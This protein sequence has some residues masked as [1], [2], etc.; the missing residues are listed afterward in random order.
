VLLSLSDAAAVFVRVLWHAQA[1]PEWRSASDPLPV[2]LAP[3]GSI[4][5]VPYD[6]E[7]FVTG[8]AAVPPAAA[9]TAAEKGTTAA[10]VDTVLSSA[11]IQSSI[12]QIGSFISSYASGPDLNMLLHEPALKKSSSSS[13]ALPVQLLRD[14]EGAVHLRSPDS[15]IKGF[16]SLLPSISAAGLAPPSADRLVHPELAAVY[17]ELA[18]GIE[19]VSRKLQGRP[20]AAALAPSCPQLQLQHYSQVTFGRLDLTWQAAMQQQQQQQKKGWV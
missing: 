5:G 11:S 9:A 4:F 18:A 13:E 6:S 12:A 1:S 10:R 3:G 16:C 8:T 2:L 14:F 20:E 19:R 17:E 7:L 15:S